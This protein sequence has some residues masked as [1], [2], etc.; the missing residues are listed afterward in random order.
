VEWFHAED[1]SV[2]FDFDN[3]FYTNEEANAA[4]GGVAASG[5]GR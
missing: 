4:F 1:K 3:R 5:G 2:H